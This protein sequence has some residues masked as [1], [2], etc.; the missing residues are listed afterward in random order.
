MTLRLAALIALIPGLAF[1][2]PGHGHT[3]PQ[4]WT[5]Y[6]TEPVHVAVLAIASVAAVFAMV[7]A[8]KRSRVSRDR[9]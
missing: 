5:H 6:L 4:S 7:R 2:H 8:R 9:E 3:D 1:A